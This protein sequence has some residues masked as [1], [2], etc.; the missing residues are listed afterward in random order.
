VF[1]RMMQRVNQIAPVAFEQ[2]SG[3][4]HRCLQVAFRNVSASP[5]K[6]EA[7]PSPPGLQVNG[8]RL[9]PGVRYK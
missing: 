6:A 1:L 4:V 5:A 7:H 8:S 3:A 2:F 9:L